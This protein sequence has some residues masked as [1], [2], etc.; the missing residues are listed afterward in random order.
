MKERSTKYPL[1]QYPNIQILA[2][3]RGQVKS[4][5]VPT[6]QQQQI[7]RFQRTLIE[8][9]YQRQDRNSIIQIKIE[10]EWDQSKFGNKL[11]C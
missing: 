4:G 10:V 2:I 6:E 5:Y 11:K 1:I 8:N 7:I 3:P 9:K